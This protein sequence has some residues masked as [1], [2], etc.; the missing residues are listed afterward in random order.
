MDFKFFLTIF[1]T[2]FLAELGD[3]TQLATMLFATNKENSKIIIFIAAALAL[4]LATL[5]A[6]VAGHCIGIFIK[7]KYLSWVAGA[8]FIIIG[9]WTMVRA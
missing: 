1:G 3:K 6:V 4:V 5:I 9:I 2:V 8:G 7:P